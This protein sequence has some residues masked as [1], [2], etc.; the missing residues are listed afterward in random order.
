M[1]VLVWRNFGVMVTA[2]SGFLEV[3]LGLKQLDNVSFSLVKSSLLASGNIS[4]ISC[5]VEPTSERQHTW[6]AKMEWVACGRWTGLMC[7]DS[8][9]RS[10]VLVNA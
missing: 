5:G 2:T 1:D 8:F 7:F 10:L 9:W 6:R 4:A 3:V